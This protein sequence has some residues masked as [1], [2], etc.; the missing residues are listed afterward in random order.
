MGIKERLRLGGNRILFAPA[1][2]LT[3]MGRMV[4]WEGRLW[5]QSLSH[6]GRHNTW[7]MSSALSFQSIM[8]VVPALVLAFL[9]L[10]SV[11]VIGNAQ[12]SV[13]RLLER[14]GFGQIYLVQEQPVTDEAGQPADAEEVN[15]AHRLEHLVADVEGKL[16]LGVLGPVGAILLIWTSLTLLNTMESSL[17]RIYEAPKSRSFW[18][19]VLLYWSA[20]TLG[21]VLLAVASILASQAG[22]TAAQIVVRLPGAA[23]ALRAA[24]WVSPL[25]FGIILLMGLY[26]L[27]PNATVSLRAAFG[28][29]AVAVPLWMLAKWGFGLYV[30][31]IVA[32]GNL[33]GSLGLIPLFLLWLNLS[34]A[35]VLL[36]AQ[37]AYTQD[38]LV[39]LELSELA[40]R[41][42]LGPVDSIMAMLAVARRFHEGKGPMPREQLA[43]E[44]SLP[45]ESVH[46]LGKQLESLSLTAC[47]DSG[48][49]GAAYAMMGPLN[50]VNLVRL[51]GLEQPLR[52]G[53]D[54]GLFPPYERLVAI[55]RQSL[56]GKSLADVVGNAPPQPAA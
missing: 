55:A 50:Q 3:R 4:M 13:R 40:Q 39:R 42:I 37:L 29:A 24:S 23:A 19:R 48:G 18:R 28:G 21:P 46:Q 6:L 10:R 52:P 17:N 47:L 33:Y 45:L 5:R 36:G 31:E 16:T 8:A 30:R 32:P 49:Q 25:F 38:N 12:E 51:I 7:A 43:R 27:M 54:P 53:L 9:V 34:W 22:H 44:L 15:V 2:E 26:K 20:M 41:T 56:A 35:I 1:G 11:G 14:A